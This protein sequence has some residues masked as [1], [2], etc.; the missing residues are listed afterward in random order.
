MS[1]I[2]LYFFKLIL[3]MSAIQKTLLTK[4]LLLCGGARRVLLNTNN[5]AFV[6]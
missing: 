4:S 6:N 1:Y 2:S 3:D 5:K